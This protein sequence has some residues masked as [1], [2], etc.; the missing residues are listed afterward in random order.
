M[1][2]ERLLELLREL[3]AAHGSITLSTDDAAT[4]QRAAAKL[5][6]WDELSALGYIDLQVQRANATAEA[7]PNGAVA[8]LTDRGIEALEDARGASGGSRSD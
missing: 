4:H 5:A 8:T 2:P 6:E 3:N 1:T 7:R